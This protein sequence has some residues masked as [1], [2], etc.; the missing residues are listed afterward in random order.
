M[1]KVFIKRFLVFSFY[2]KFLN[3]LKNFLQKFLT[4]TNIN[5]KIQINPTSHEK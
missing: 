1:R 2:K 5:Q 4:L 3:K